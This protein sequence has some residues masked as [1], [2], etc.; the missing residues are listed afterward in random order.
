MHRR[1]LGLIAGVGLAAMACKD[2]TSVGDLNNVSS[3]A[4]A[5]GLNK[6]LNGL[7]VTGQ[8]NSTRGDLDSR[9]IVFSETM[10]RDFY[11]LDNAESRYITETIGG[12]ADFSGFLGGG[13]FSQFYVTV[14]AG[15]TILNAI[16]KASRPHA[17]RSVGDEGSGA[18]VQRARTL[19]RDRTA[20]LARHRDRRE[21]PDRGATGGVR[22]Q[23]ERA[24]LDLGVARQ[25]GD[26]S[27]RWWDG[28]PIQAARWLLVERR[29]NTPAS[30][31]ESTAP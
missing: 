8:I 30:S 16:P 15:N 2:S 20:R 24:G 7:L 4:I 17:R 10:A 13:A 1:T 5:G 26:G 21:P 12:P 19:P 14:R 31:C 23:A 29:F 18:H 25:R 27:C 6:N 11:R 3:Q 22:L 9:Y 28:V